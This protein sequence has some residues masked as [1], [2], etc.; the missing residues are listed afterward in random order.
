MDAVPHITNVTVTFIVS[1]IISF[2]YLSLRQVA[3]TELR[4]TFASD[5]GPLWKVVY[6]EKAECGPDEGVDVA[7]KTGTE[8][9]RQKRKSSSPCHEGVLLFKIHHVIA[10]GVSMLDMLQRQLVPMLNSSLRRDSD[11]AVPQFFASLPMAPP[12]DESFIK[13]NQ[14]SWTKRRSLRS[15]SMR[16]S[17]PQSADGKAATEAPSSEPLL[18]IEDATKRTAE[19]E[20]RLLTLSFGAAV[21]RRFVE[22]CGSSGVDFEEAM[23]TAAATSLAVT[24]AFCHVDLHSDVIVCGRPVDLRRYHTLHAHYEPLGHWIACDMVRVSAPRRPPNDHRFW[25]DARAVATSI[26]SHERPWKSLCLYGEVAKALSCS[27]D[28]IRHKMFRVHL[29]V[30][31]LTADSGRTTTDGPVTMDGHY[32]VKS[33]SDVTPATMAL[34][35]TLLRGR[36]MCTIAYNSR[37]V[38]REF[39]VKFTETLRWLI[40]HVV[41]TTARGGP[42]DTCHTESDHPRCYYNCMLANI[43]YYSELFIILNVVLLSD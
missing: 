14:L 7:G 25:T 40:P 26:G 29:E 15:A 32:F 21:G 35:S 30:V 1:N 28:V 31:S 6:V 41:S 17:S 9:T 18:R 43:L 11:N 27:T 38:S 19:S 2:D 13:K 16:A 42:G 37:W 24:A 39:A 23:L 34:T 20:T 12:A 8:K 10:D 33:M 36:I 22:R 3:Q 4:K 5:R